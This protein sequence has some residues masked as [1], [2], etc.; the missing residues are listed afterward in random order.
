Q[1]GRGDWV[2]TRANQRTLICHRGRD[3]VKNDDRWQIQRRHTD[4]SLTVQHL[5]HRGP[6]RLPAEYVA[7]HVELA[8]ASTAHRAQGVTVDTAHPLVPTT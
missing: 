2:L 1:A 3:W 5:T 6:V 8:Y 4:G 7:E